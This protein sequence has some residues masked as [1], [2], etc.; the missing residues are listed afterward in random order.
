MITIEQKTVEALKAM[1]A[2]S[3]EKAVNTAQL[4]VYMGR[5]T[6]N[7]ASTL[8]KLLEKTKSVAREPRD[9][10]D[11]FYWW[12]VGEYIPKRR[13]L[14]V[15]RRHRRPASSATTTAPNTNAVTVCV[16]L[17]GEMLLE[18]DVTTAQAS[19]ILGLIRS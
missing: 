19:A 15:R 5:D 10:T 4:G 1:G 6:S 18:R 17:N 12:C 7:C 2:T 16:K 9:G 14:N 3:C 11:R 13:R 8:H